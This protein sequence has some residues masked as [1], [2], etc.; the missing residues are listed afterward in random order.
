[1]LDPRPAPDEMGPFYAH[2]YSDDELA[3]VTRFMDAAAELAMAHA[4]ALRE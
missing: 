3:V 4:R 1:M 2:Y